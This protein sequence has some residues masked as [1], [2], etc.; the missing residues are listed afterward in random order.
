MR[1]S[2]SRAFILLGALLGTLLFSLDQLVVATAMPQIVR[3]LN[4]LS[5]LSWVFTAY[6]LTST[7]TIPIYGKL[8]DVFGRRGSYI[9]G[10]AVFLVG[11][12]LSGISQNMTELILFRALQG[13]GGGAMMVTAVAIVGDIFSPA[14]RAKWQGLNMGMYGI[15][16]IAG[17]VLGGWL[18]DNFSWRWVFYINIPIGIL[19]IVI[20][21][22][23]MPRIAR[24]VQDRAVDLPGALLIA[25][26]LAPLLLAL[27]WGG[28]KYPWASWQVVVLLFVAVS[29]LFTLVLVEQKTHD[30]IL[31]LSLFKNKTYTISIMATFLTHSGLYGALLYIPLFAQGVIGMS[32]T[33]SGLILMPMMIGLISASVLSG[34]IVS[35][36]GKYKVLTI[37]GMIVTVLGMALL[38]QIG[39]KTTNIALS[40]R[41]VILGIGMGVG[42][43]IFITMVQSAFGQE[44]LGE[45]TAGYQLFRNIGGTVGTAIL[46]GVLN[47][48]LASQLASIQSDPFI[49]MLKQL[50][51]AA[52]L[53][54]IGVN[55]IQGFL[56]KDGQAQIRAM[57]AK[58]PQD[59]QS[60]LSTSFDHFLNTIKTA[61]SH[62]V[63]HVFIIS[64]IL[65]VAAL[66]LVFFLPQIPLRRGKHS[67]LEEAELESG[68][69]IGTQTDS[70]DRPQL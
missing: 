42:M 3:E 23:Y 26:G 33:N 12:I 35:G 24:R 41:M 60:Q 21:A 13:I 2:S 47:S 28:D 17:P 61:F 62:S 27:T 46:G 49:A 14:E 51:P 25:T 39:V 70:K 53:T 40:W 34:L 50:D 68:T 20:A 64:T 18:T 58:A 15:A 9:L 44:K 52:A 48:Q 31:S 22:A 10:I 57:I 36:T 19:A 6:M 4:G 16:T 43:T 65:M 66:V 69:E 63:D 45:V 11:S 8:S 55:T 59:M 56:S 29:A 1:K 30:P 38:V 67:A 7:V 37:I 32:A 5:Q 54:K